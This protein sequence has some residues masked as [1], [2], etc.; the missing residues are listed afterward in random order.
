MMAR[1][2]LK[3]NILDTLSA[4]KEILVQDSIK[5]IFPRSKMV[6]TKV[7]KFLKYQT[8]FIY[9]KKPK[10]PQMTKTGFS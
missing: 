7:S 10:N 5:R 3:D 1:I 2:L 8:N 6:D 9:L 4:Y